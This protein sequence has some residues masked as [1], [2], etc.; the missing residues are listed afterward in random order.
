MQAFPILVFQKC[1]KYVN[2]SRWYPSHPCPR[3]LWKRMIWQIIYWTRAHM[4]NTVH[5]LT[6]CLGWQVSVVT[7]DPLLRIMLWFSKCQPIL[8]SKCA[9]SK[10]VHRALQRPEGIGIALV[11]KCQVWLQILSQE[12]ERRRRHRLWREQKE[13]E[14]EEKEE[15]EEGG[16]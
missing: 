12:I 10:E 16:R 7:A 11:D 5:Y 14:E 15:E 4:Q 8:K 1:S 9:K 6:S 3:Y 2:T 13:R